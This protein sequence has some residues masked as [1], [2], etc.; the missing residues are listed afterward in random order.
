MNV[1]HHKISTNHPPLN[2]IDL[3]H[4]R[5]KRK[6][7]ATHHSS[8]CIPNTNY[9]TTTTLIMTLLRSSNLNSSYKTLDTNY[10]TFTLQSVYVYTDIMK[11]KNKTTTTACGKDF[12][13]SFKPNDTSLIIMHSE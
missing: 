13:Y 3:S 1:T 5:M 9:T 7:C 8:C 4:T 6:V 2:F 10:I 11:K 12:A